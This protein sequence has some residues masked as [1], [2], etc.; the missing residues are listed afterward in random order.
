[1]ENK[2]FAPW[3]MAYILSNSDDNEQKEPGCIFCEFPKM[4]EDEKNLIL[5]RGKECFV[6][7]RAEGPEHDE[8]DNGCD[9][10]GCFRGAL[11]SVMPS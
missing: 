1:M 6:I 2:I 11:D 4:N 9:V 8:K 7:L 10:S 5:H 3:R